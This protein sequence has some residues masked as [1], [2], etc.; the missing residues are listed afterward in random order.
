MNSDWDSEDEQT[1]VKI[2]SSLHVPINAEVKEEYDE[3]VK[4]DCDDMWWY[5]KEERKKEE[6]EK[7]QKLMRNNFIKERE[8]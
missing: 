2:T 4:A 5:W 1:E 7:A 3:W 8:I 6:V